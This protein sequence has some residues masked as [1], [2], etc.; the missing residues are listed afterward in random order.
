MPLDMTCITFIAAAAVH[1]IRACNYQNESD[2]RPWTIL[3]DS[4]MLASIAAHDD[5]DSRIVCH[6]AARLRLWGIPKLLRRA[7]CLATFH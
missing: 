3:L 5:T 4:L 2:L 1:R 7:R 6:E